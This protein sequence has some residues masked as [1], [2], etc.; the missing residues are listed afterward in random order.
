MTSFI[1]NTKSK[2]ANTNQRV[3][4]EYQILPPY[5]GLDQTPAIFNKTNSRYPKT[6]FFNSTIT[7]Y[8]GGYSDGNY[9]GKGILVVVSVPKILI[10]SQDDKVKLRKIEYAPDI[11]SVLTTM[12]YR[13]QLENG[14][15]NGKGMLWRFDETGI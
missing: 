8:E 7:F 5:Q 12:R 2:K 9:N 1:D 4:Y 6:I 11:N 15:P 13:G 3:L 14:E 10:F